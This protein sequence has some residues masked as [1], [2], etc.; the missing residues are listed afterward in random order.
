MA[1]SVCETR[2]SNVI[3]EGGKRGGS[4]GNGVEG[5]GERRAARTCDRSGK[6]DGAGGS[7]RRGNGSGDPA[8]RRYRQ[9][10]RASP[11]AGSLTACWRAACSL[12]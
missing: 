2:L 8:P 6:H 11:Y 5:R 12:R 7:L 9:E 3:R 4:E 1:Q 10:R